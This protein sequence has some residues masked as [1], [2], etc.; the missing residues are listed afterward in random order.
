MQK[1]WN[2]SRWGFKISLPFPWNNIHPRLNHKNTIFLQEL[3]F[4]S[5]EGRKPISN[6]QL[7]LFLPPVFLW[8]WSKE[9][10]PTSLVY[11]LIML[12]LRS[13]G[14]SDHLPLATRTAR[15]KELNSRRKWRN[16]D[17]SSVLI[18]KAQDHLPSGEEYNCQG[19]HHLLMFQPVQQPHKKK[20]LLSED[21][22]LHQITWS[23][24][25]VLMP[26]RSAL[27]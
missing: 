24:Q 27:M 10:Y 25:A 23:P 4:P 22:M 20:L 11:K 13:L 5:P 15:S 12:H 18:L 6:S 3:E 26:G 21:H 8:R 7:L 14:T 2:L 9:R 16:Q 17:R 1:T 19:S